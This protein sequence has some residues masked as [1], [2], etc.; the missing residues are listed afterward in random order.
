MF[1]RSSN[2]SA[3][4]CGRWRTG[5]SQPSLTREG[6][7]SS[8]CVASGS[9]LSGGAVFSQSCETEET[10]GRHDH[11]ERG[12]TVAIWHRNNLS[13]FILFI[14]PSPYVAVPLGGDLRDSKRKQRHHEQ[15]DCKLSH[16]WPPFRRN[17]H[18]I[19]NKGQQ[20]TSQLLE[21]TQKG[22]FT[23]F[24]SKGRQSPLRLLVP[25]SADNVQLHGSIP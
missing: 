23:T 1:R 18:N 13:G 22:S 8:G 16:Q 17:L 11:H 4:N 20:Q 5:A 12:R 14:S 15:R 25:P 24:L 3:T 2:R 10:R 6:D 19:T 7:A 9:L 21:Q